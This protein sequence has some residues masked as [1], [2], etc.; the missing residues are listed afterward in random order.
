MCGGGPEIDKTPQLRQ[1]DAAAEARARE[2]ARQ[3][4]VETG[5]SFLDAMFRGG[6]VNTAGLD[7]EAY[8]TNPDA[9]LGAADFDVRTG[10]GE[11]RAFR[12]YDPYLADYEQTL[13]SFYQPQLEDQ[14]SDTEDQLK[15]G[16]ARAGQAASSQAAEQYGDLTNTF[17]IR[18][19]ELLSTIDGRVDERRSQF[20][21]TR[22]ALED[23]LLQTGDASR[24]A[25]EATSQIDQLYAK[26]PDLN[27]LGDVFAN[28]A[29]AYG[30][31]GA[32]RQRGQIAG[33]YDSPSVTERAPKTRSSGTFIS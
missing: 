31:Y 14:Y 26:Q 32:G 19:N 2:D 25:G 13:G 15:Y 27:Q 1:Q 17:D 23:M 29:S 30:A 20:E 22:G 7:A 5:Q 3:R 12:G 24:V 21:A 28:A 4:R 33:V 6:E 18:Q 9:K 10:A 8:R 16:L 11:T